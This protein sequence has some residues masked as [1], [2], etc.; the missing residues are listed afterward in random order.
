[1]LLPQQNPLVLTSAL[2]LMKALH[3]QLVAVLAV[4]GGQ[5]PGAE[6]IFED[7]SPSEGLD[8]QLAA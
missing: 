3:L 7:A 4:E 5:R 6:V 2:I 1:M 8:S